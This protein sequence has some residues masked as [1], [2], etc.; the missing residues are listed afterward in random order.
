MRL[1]GLAILIATAAVASCDAGRDSRE[2]AGNQSPRGPD[3]ARGELLSLAC[4]ACHTLG[5]GGPHLVGPNLH[6]V[7]GRRVGSAAEFAYSPAL[8]AADIV[9]APETLDAWLADPVGFLP[10]TTMAFTGYQSPRDREDLIAYL[11]NAT[12]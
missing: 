12:K 6:A 11:V 7:F 9:W 8:K 5:A 3:L 4:Q 10:G 1:G 2:P